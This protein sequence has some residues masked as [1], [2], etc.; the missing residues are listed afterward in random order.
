MKNKKQTSLLRYWTTRYLLTILIGLIIIGVISTL[1]INY[2]A[3]MR[4][5]DIM[6]LLA[7]EIS[8]RIVGPQGQIQIDYFLPKVLE[9]GERFIHL[10]TKP[11]Y[12]ILDKDKKIIFSKPIGIPQEF[13]ARISTTIDDNNNLEQ[14]V[15]NHG[16]NVYVVKRSIT[17]N[18]NTI[19]WVI[20]LLPKTGV[21][22][23]LEQVRL[24][25]IMLGSL[26]I[27]GWMVIYLLTKKLSEPIK[28]VADAAKQIVEGNYRVELK[29]NIKEKEINELVESFKDMA[30]RLQQLEMMRTELLAGVTHELKTPVTSISAL[31]QAVKDDIVTGEEAKEFLDITTKET[32]RLQKMVEDLLDFNSFAIGELKVNKKDY[33]MN[34]LVEEI[35]Y[36]WDIV[37][38]ENPIKLTTK[39]P[40][41]TLMTYTDSARVQQILYNLLN[42]S[43]QAIKGKGTIEVT[44]YETEA[45]IRIDVADNGPG[46]LAEEKDLVFER[47]FRGR[48][49]K[50][51]VHGL[52]LG[53]SFSKILAKGLD[54]ELLLKETSK[55]GTTFTLAL[56]KLK[57]Q[58]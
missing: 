42:N 48:D 39:L 31:V 3:T 25:I 49:K 23:N 29:K 11:F 33:N 21:F 15:L 32:N 16:I 36:Q 7:E 1:W 13:L 14:L 4:Q 51:T 44:L 35:I 12:M 52:G 37:Q 18:D 34:Q 19:G 30:N 20:I 57:A 54:G 38:E 58:P 2:F 27:L 26:A 47:F 43:K 8:D 9:R 50:Q 40:E 17:Y 41:H 10:D 6:K 53:L 5:L 22:I 24:I 45:D 56:P 46:I 55:A 28:E